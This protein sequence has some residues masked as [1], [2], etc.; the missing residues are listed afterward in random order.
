[1]ELPGV[2]LRGRGP[3]QDAWE[4]ISEVT[5]DDAETTTRRRSTARSTT[6]TMRTRN[7]EER[8]WMWETNPL[9]S[10]WRP[11]SEDW[12]TRTFLKGWAEWKPASDGSRKP[13]GSELRAPGIPLLFLNVQY[14][15][16]IIESI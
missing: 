4:E 1:V 10:G 5:E 8:P 11:K 12:G 16:I 15:I 3:W 2:E 6:T 7:D 14:Y 13:A 9:T